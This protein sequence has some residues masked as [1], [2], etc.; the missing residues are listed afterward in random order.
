M[1]EAKSIV[2]FANLL[3]FGVCHKMA[4][5]SSQQQTENSPRKLSEQL[6]Q[7]PWFRNL[8]S[9]IQEMQHLQILFNSVCEIELA[10]HCQVSMVKNGVL[11]LQITSAGWATRLRYQTP[12]LIKSLAKF[13]EFRGVKTIQIKVSANTAPVNRQLLPTPISAESAESIA[14]IAEGIKDKDLQAAMR[15]L[16]G[17]R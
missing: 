5:Q 6:A 11:Y 10:Q 9:H 1:H 13:Q 16:A 17:K 7:A 3:I 8:S 12:E 2:E 4:P 15:K 14:Q